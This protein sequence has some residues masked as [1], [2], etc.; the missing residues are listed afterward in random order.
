[1]ITKIKETIAKYFNEFYKILPITGML[2]ISLLVSTALLLV[3]EYNTLTKVIEKISIKVSIILV[4]SIVMFI[5]LWSINIHL[6]DLFK[7][8]TVNVVDKIFFILSV[9]CVVTSIYWKFSEKIDNYKYISS[10][11]LLVI[12]LVFWI[13]KICLYIKN[14]LGLVDIGNDIYDLQK[15]Y[16]NDFARRGDE[17][18]L[19]AEKDVDYDLLER[20]IVINQLYN[21][22]IS[23]NPVNSFVIGLEGK[24]GSGKTTIIN[25]V[26]LKLK[27]KEDIV[28]IDELEPWI[29]GNQ[30]ALLLAMYDIIL[31]KSGIGFS[32]YN[33]HRIIKSLK[34][35]VAT[36]YSVGEMIID[37]AFNKREYNAIIQVKEKLE[38]YL[39]NSKKKVVFFI[40]NIDRAEADNIIFLLKLIG[41]IF[42]LPHILYVLSYDRNRVDEI[43]KDTEKINPQ[44]I[45]KIIQQEIKIPLISKE[46]LT[47]VYDICVTNIL[48]QY[49][50]E[51]DKLS[52]HKEWFNLVCENID[53]LRGFKRF[54]NSVFGLV[55][56]TDKSL[57][58]IQLM[59]IE[60]IKFLEPQLYEQIR[61]NRKF[62][63]S[64]NQMTDGAIYK[65][66]FNREKFNQEGKSFFS[67]LFKK[68]DSYQ[69]ILAY[70]FPYANRY[71]NNQDLI[72]KYGDMAAD[73]SNSAMANIYSAKYFDSYFS[74]GTSSYLDINS[75]VLDF[76]EMIQEISDEKTLYSSFEQVIKNIE[77]HQQKEWFERLQNYI[78]DIPQEMK[79]IIAR[80][81][82][83]NIYLINASQQFFSL[84]ARDRVEVIIASLLESISIENFEYFAKRISKNY[85]KLNVISRIIYWLENSKSEI[86]D[87]E[88][89]KN[90]LLQV[91]HTMCDKVKNGEVDLYQDEYYFRNNI[92]AF[93]RN[94][95]EEDD[96]KKYTRRYISNIVSE[97]NII[98]IINDL[99]TTSVG[100]KYGYSINERNVEIFF[101]DAS[102]IDK[103]ITNIYPQTDTEKFILAVY[104][105]YKSGEKNDFGESAI[106]TDY[107]VILEL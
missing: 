12:T 75:S 31:E 65:E 44:Y 46:R 79:V 7:I 36:N 56:I 5:L 32:M 52:Q 35:N 76:I 94:F 33:S 18:I 48:L 59:S 98:R 71:K 21:S 37:L 72:P 103:F 70:L 100:T 62:F 81:L 95:E 25:N 96:K 39:R 47:K 82:F 41:T 15:I 19:I 57:D 83:E 26:K 30:E 85:N 13:I 23:Y 4:I 3:D 92:W 63:V 8:N 90:S 67:N 106:Y 38:I 86:K 10:I 20:D 49:G 77:K 99:I 93:V 1:M 64:H 40:D 28:V 2:Q 105:K 80:V 42:E 27:N 69:D 102:V 91:Y 78:V 6:I 87:I 84:S 9:I 68:Y 14:Q 24:W 74:Y 43:L 73:N 45:E 101:E 22:I 17:P 16:K 60:T 61:D 66:I 97:E 104:E 29:F 89:R 107:E 50:V 11:I 55:F 88:S 58:K 51:V 34:K 54:V 53:N